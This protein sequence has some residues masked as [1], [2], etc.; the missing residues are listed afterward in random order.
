MNPSDGAKPGRRL[1]LRVHSATPS[2]G[3]WHQETETDLSGLPEE[4]APRR[5][6]AG[7]SKNLDPF[8]TSLQS[9]QIRSKALRT[10]VPRG[11]LLVRHVPRVRDRSLGSS[12]LESRSTETPLVVPRPSENF[13]RR[14]MSKQITTK[15][16]VLLL[17]HPIREPLGV[18]ARS[19]LHGGICL[20]SRAQ[21]GKQ[22]W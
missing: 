10:K 15:V 22:P 4:R 2:M 8:R 21:C 6:K 17:R 19:F 13:D 7:G 11:C 9:G 3:P 5:P 18:K 16:P 1:S 14:C 12:S 20:V